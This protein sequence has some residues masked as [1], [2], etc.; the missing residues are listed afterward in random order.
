M[1][2]KRHTEEQMLQVLN[3]ADGGQT[4]ADVCRN[5]GVSE[6]TFYAWKKKYAG[7]GLA[8]L[9]ELRPRY[10]QVASCCVSFSYSP[11]AAQKDRRSVH[12]MRRERRFSRQAAR[13]AVVGTIAGLCCTCVR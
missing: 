12:K 11:L 8:E 5:A 9:R 7:L 13:W 2:R 6:A 10:P 1:P 4:V 3:M